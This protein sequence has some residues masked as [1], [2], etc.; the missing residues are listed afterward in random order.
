MIA[1]V[2]IPAGLENRSERAGCGFEKVLE[3]V[4]ELLK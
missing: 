1:C 3:Y 4:G 2:A